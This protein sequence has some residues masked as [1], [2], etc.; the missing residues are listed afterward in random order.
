MG[1]QWFQKIT[2][3]VFC[4]SAGKTTTTNKKTKN[5]NKTNLINAS[6]SVDPWLKNNRGTEESQL[7]WNTLVSSVCFVII[8]LKGI[9][10]MHKI[11]FH[12]YSASHVVPLRDFILF[13]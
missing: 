6:V 1:K 5:K 3:C 8:L 13:A 4:H 7:V 9:F 2:M 11:T 10:K 12:N